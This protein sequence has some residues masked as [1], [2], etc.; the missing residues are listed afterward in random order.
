MR[1]CLGEQASWTMEFHF[2]ELPLDHL[3]HLEG[4]GRL[5]AAESR[6]AKG[7]SNCG[8]IVRNVIK[9]ENK[10]AMYSR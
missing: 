7:M 4:T 5:H 3:M 6:Q 1:G 8:A 10:E 9:V 2:H